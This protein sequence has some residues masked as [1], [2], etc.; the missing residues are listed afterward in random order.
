YAPLAGDLDDQPDDARRPAAAI[1]NDDV[2]GPADAVAGGVE[3]GAPGQ[4][5]DENP[6]RAHAQTLLAHAVLAEERAV[7]A[8]SWRA[9][10]CAAPQ[11][12]VRYWRREQPDTFRPPCRRHSAPAQGRC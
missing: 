6:R 5:G 11:P 12:P 10:D 2:V 8:A 3:D 9:F 4:P 7:F 1:H